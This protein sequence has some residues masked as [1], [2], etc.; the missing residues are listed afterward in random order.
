[1]QDYMP[2]SGAMWLFSSYPCLRQVIVTL[3]TDRSF[4]G[5]LW[6]KRRG[7]LVLRNAEMLQPGGAI[8]HMDGE[9][10]IESANVDFV[11]VVS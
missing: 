11:Q 3:K 7:Y 1:M 10:V 2:K 8:V 4:R 5:V 6:R 9:I